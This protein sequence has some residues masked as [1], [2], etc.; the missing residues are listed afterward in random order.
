L[1]IPA[2]ADGVSL[3]LIATAFAQETPE[4]ASA[5]WRTVADQIRP[6]VAK[7]AAIMDD[8]ENDVLA[9]MTFPKEH[10]LKLDSTSPVERLNG[11]IK[12][13]TVVVGNFANED[14]II[15]LVRAIVLAQNDE[16]TVPPGRY[17]SLETI[18]PLSDVARSGRLT[19][20]PVCRRSQEHSFHTTFRDTIGSGGHRG[21]RRY[22]IDGMLDWDFHAVWPDQQVG[23]WL[24]RT[25]WL[26]PEEDGCFGR[27]P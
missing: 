27:T 12:R 5:Q 13:R 8:A 15:R 1:P 22:P 19:I 26:R 25:I 14:A 23:R 17:M 21:R 2:R 24:G 4:A 20:R 6:Q 16:W 7:L 3:R 10:R 9:Y 11:E 18:A